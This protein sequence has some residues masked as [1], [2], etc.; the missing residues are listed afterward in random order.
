[1]YMYNQEYEKITKVKGC[2]PD[3]WTYL[4]CCYFML[5]MYQEADSVAQKGRWWWCAAVTVA[6]SILYSNMVCWH[7]CMAWLVPQSAELCWSC[8]SCSLSACLCSL[9]V[10][11][12]FRSYQHHS[13][14]HWVLISDVV[15]DRRS[16]DKTGLRPKNRSWS[17]SCTLWSWS[18]SC[19]LW[20][21]SCRSG[22]VLW[23]TIVTLFNIMILKDTATF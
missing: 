8:I 20:S 12:I 5:G 9:P 6:S 19:T 22:V 23:K 17:W 15:S 21:W 18:W 13:W 3:M 4:G 16:S 7:C 10:N 14:V 11:M 1:M 2:H